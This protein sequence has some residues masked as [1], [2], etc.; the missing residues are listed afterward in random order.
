VSKHRHSFETHLH[1]LLLRKEA[2][3]ARVLKSVYELER[4]GDALAQTIARRRADLDVLKGRPRSPDKE[5]P[6]GDRD[7]LLARVSELEHALK[8]QGIHHK[9]SSAALTQA[10]AEVAAFRAS[11]SWKLTAPVRAVYDLLLKVRR[12]PTA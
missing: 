11:A 5:A 2:A 9:E 8:R 4:Q 12:N 10:Q 6:G 1:D 3:T 7:A